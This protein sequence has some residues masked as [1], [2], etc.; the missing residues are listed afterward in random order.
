MYNSDFIVYGLYNNTRSLYWYYSHIKIVKII[1]DENNNITKKSANLY[2]D[3][4]ME[5]LERIFC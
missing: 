1:V 2:R 5:K 3:S 4:L